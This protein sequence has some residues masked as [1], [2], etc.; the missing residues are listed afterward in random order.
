MRT[1]RNYPQAPSVRQI[2]NWRLD[3][4]MGPQAKELATA[5]HGGGTI[6]SSV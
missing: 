3:R 1:L 6:A 5:A 4:R 2:L